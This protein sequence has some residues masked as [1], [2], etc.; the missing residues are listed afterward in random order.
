MSRHLILIGVIAAIFCSCGDGSALVAPQKSESAKLP[1]V[2]LTELVSVPENIPE[3]PTTLMASVCE[4]A[5]ACK[6]KLPNFIR[7]LNPEMLLAAA[8]ATQKVDNSAKPQTIDIDPCLAGGAI[9]I[10]CFNLSDETQ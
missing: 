8:A 5:Q 4:D 2:N 1:S 3:S 9:S 7:K 10:Q 6:P